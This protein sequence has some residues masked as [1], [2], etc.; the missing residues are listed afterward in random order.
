MTFKTTVIAHQEILL[1]VTELWQVHEWDSIGSS[2]AQQVFAIGRVWVL[3][4]VVMPGSVS[5][6][7]SSLFK[8]DSFSVKG[9]V[10]TFDFDIPVSEV[11]SV[12][13]S[14]NSIILHLL[15]EV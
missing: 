15:G 8:V 1:N 6:T 9:I 12:E 10:N 5:I 14:N 2:A 4:L 3:V 13:S 11:I 7:S